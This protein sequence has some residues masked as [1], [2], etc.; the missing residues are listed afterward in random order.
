MV[1]ARSFRH[2]RKSG[3]FSPHDKPPLGSK[4][5]EGHPLTPTHAYW[6]NEYA[7]NTVFDCV[8]NKT[9]S[10]ND[11]SI[12]SW[13]A[14]GVRFTGA[15][16]SRIDLGTLPL[17]DV[18]YDHSIVIG[19][20][21]DSWAANS[22]GCI[23]KLGSLTGDFLGYFLI[24]ETANQIWRYQDLTWAGG[25]FANIDYQMVYT[26]TGDGDVSANEKMFINGVERASTT[27][28][29]AGTPPITNAWNIGQVS[30]G[31]Y[32]YAG[33]VKYVFFYDRQLS[34]EE[35]V[36]MWINPRQWVRP[37]GPHRGALW[38]TAADGL[39]IPIVMY[40]YTHH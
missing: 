26:M 23:L 14:G 2:D 34:D 5:I 39:S 27:G 22:Y 9:G 12:V 4:P 31:S 3:L 8:R 6:L 37:P 17:I 36:S 18:Q 20:R 11:P 40:H 32:P 19:F 16:G 13:E 38:V 29:T 30:S 33:L 24:R 7:G 1:A 28:I 15:V 21:R 35:A 10:F 25:I